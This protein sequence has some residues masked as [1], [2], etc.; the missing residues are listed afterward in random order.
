M[1][2]RKSRVETAIGRITLMED[3]FD[4]ASV[5]LEK[6]KEDPDHFLAFQ[7]EISK[8]EE[9]YSGRRWKTDFKL[10]EEGKL[11]SDL[12]RGVLSEDGLYDLLE[13]NRELLEEMKD[14]S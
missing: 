6:A 1:G 9:Y 8:L 2:N 5:V 3:L 11:P 14:K 7:N 13:K 4:K 12:K 10:D